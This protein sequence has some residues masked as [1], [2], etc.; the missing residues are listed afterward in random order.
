[1]NDTPDGVNRRFD[2]AAPLP[3]LADIRAAHLIAIGGSGMSGVARL[4]LDAGVEVSGSDRAESAVLDELRAAGAEVRI[5]QTAEGAQLVPD[6]AVVVVSSAIAEDNPELAAVRARG[7]PVLHRAQAL[8]VL[9]AGRSALAVAGTSGKTTT[10]AMATVALR[11]AGADP[12]FA[13]GAPIVGIGANSGVGQGDSFVVEADE[14]DGSFVVYRPE[15]AIVTS[16]RDDHLDF[17]GTS[18]RLRRAYADFADTIRAGGLLVACADDP[19]AAGLA[20]RHREM[21]RRV[22]TYGRTA[23]ADLRLAEESG[24]GFD[25][26]ATLLPATGGRMPLR[27][28]V[29]GAHNLQNAAG[30]ALALT[31][32]FGLPMEQVLAGLGEFGGTARRLEPRGEAG[33]VRVIDDY[34]HNPD[35]LDAAVRAGVGLRGG[36][37][38]IAVFQPHL[39]SRTQHAA[40]GL[41]AALSLADVAI[42]LDVYPAREAPVPGVTG[43]LVADQVTDAEVVHAPTLDDALQATLDRARPGDLVLTVGAGDVTTLGPRILQALSKP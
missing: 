4:L 14:S 24:T 35:K 43:A 11:A 38:L 30:V 17:Y 31:E 25:W 7:I 9:L 10:S 42:V 19:G 33:G 12:S 21:G 8:G 22:V 15:V 6:D 32:G 23:D 26:S 37:R 29:P 5:G 1:M 39:F 36:G 27:L 2:F 41:A 40:S 18:E 16:V 3:A 28:K 20:A 13:I 34:A